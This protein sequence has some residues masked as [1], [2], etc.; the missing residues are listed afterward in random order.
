MDAQ[1]V[2]ALQ[3]DPRAAFSSVAADLGVA[4]QTVARHYRRLRRDGLVRV[5]GSVD[6]PALGEDD[7]LVRVHCRPDGARAVAEAL[8]RRD[9]AAWV[10]IAAGG[11]EVS[12]SMHPRTQQDRDDLLEQRLPRSAP[13]LDI[14]AA[15][16][17]HRFVGNHAVDWRGR[18]K[19]LTEQGASAQGRDV[20]LEESDHRLLELL[21]RDGRTSY[22]VLAR[23]TGLSIGRVTRRIAALQEGGILY[24]DLDMSPAALGHGLAAYM[25]LNVGPA[26]LESVGSALADFDETTYVAAVTGP[27]NLF[28]TLICP[29][30]SAL[31]RFM[32]TKMAAL[33]GINNFELVPV[34]RRL[35]QAGSITSGDRLAGPTPARRRA[36]QPGPRSR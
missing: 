22:A 32:S 6:S 16:I 12:F 20:Q 28:A 33:Q 11:A 26:Q 4:E 3:L 14:T 10:S 34:L 17:L 5:I 27:F 25:W 35:K 24:F 23:A 8:A 30:T 31:Y 2:Q 18:H 15:L 13:V 9:D 19:I 21:A 7:W 29:G 1:I 36:G